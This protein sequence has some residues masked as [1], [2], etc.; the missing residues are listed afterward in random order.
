[1]RERMLELARGLE[2]DG[3]GE[4][5]A[6]V[7]E[8]A[9]FLRWAADDHFTFLGYREYDL[10]TRCRAGGGQARRR[11]GAGDPA[12]AAARSVQAASPQ[13]DGDRPVAGSADPHQG[14]LAGDR[15]PALI[16]RLHRREAIRRGWTGRRRVPLPRALHEHRVPDERSRDPAAPGQ[17]PGRARARG[18][19][20]RQPR[21]EGAAGDPRD[22]PARLAAADGRGRSVRDRDRAARTRRAA[23]GEAV[24]L[25]GPAR[26]VRH[27]PGDDSPRSLTSPTTASG[28]GGS[29]SRRSPARSWTTRCSSRSRCWS[30]STTSYGTPPASPTGR[31]WR[32]S[33]SGWSGPRAHGPTTC[34][35]R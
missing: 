22:L 21:R 33:R 24:R 5:P 4:G 35:W 30:G 8:S 31:T 26:A 7:E 25:A 28:S 12:T 32:R 17:G 13:G 16:S 6:Q 34:G 14:E 20:K 27:L 18:V 1:M 10:V 11:L 15:P 3:P 29:C 2:R 23:V 9:A 19:P